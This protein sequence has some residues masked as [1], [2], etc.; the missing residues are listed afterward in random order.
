MFILWVGREEGKDSNG[1]GLVLVGGREEVFE[2][3]DWELFLGR[4]EESF[5]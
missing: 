3:G 2:D 1:G 4:R 5:F